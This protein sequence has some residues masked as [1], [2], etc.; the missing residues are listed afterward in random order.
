[1]ERGCILLKNKLAE[2]VG[3]WAGGIVKRVTPVDALKGELL[4]AIPVDKIIPRSDGKRPHN[5]RLV[6][7]KAITGHANPDDIAPLS[8]HDYLLLLPIESPLVR[9]EV[10]V[11]NKMMWGRGLKPGD[12]VYV[13]IQGRV[14][15]S[16]IIRC[17]VEVS[18]HSGLLF[19][20]EIKVK[21]RIIIIVPHTQ[22]VLRFMS[23]FA[24]RFYAEE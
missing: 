15:V 21:T 17:I 10:F 5:Y 20:V 3:T 4:F 6:K 18:N 9:Y 14:N 7:D 12:A 8:D 19:G 16:A 11:A 1:M 22:L 2:R 13:A 24:C 23:T